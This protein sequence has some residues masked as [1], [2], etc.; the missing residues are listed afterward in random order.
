M[1]AQTTV[2]QTSKFEQLLADLKIPSGD[3]IC[4][5]QQRTPLPNPASKP[6]RAPSSDSTPAATTR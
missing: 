5:P 4:V 6:A 2:D 1:S 3:L